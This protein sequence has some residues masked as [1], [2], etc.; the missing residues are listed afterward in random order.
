M[1]WSKKVIGKGDAGDFYKGAFRGDFLMGDLRRDFMDKKVF[2]PKA[3]VDVTGGTTSDCV[4][5]PSPIF[6]LTTGAVAKIPLVLAE[7]TVQVNVG[8]VIDLPEPAFEIKQI[9]KRVKVT[10]CILLQD[11][12]V[13][14]LKGFV[15]K[16]IDYSTSGK[17]HNKTG[18][19]GDIRHCTID[20]PWTCTT[21]V[22]FNGVNPL[23][24]VLTTNEEFV[25]FRVQDLKG[26][27]FADKD[28][29]LSSDLSEHNQISTEFY[30]ELPFC[31]L[32]SSRIVEFD[33]F[34]N[35][36]EPGIDKLPFD[37]KGYD[38]ANWCKFPFEE[39]TFKSIEEKMVIFLTLKL[40]QNQ[41]VAIPPLLPIFKPCED[42]K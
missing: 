13:L 15:R 23:P 40:L 7:F 42:N 33:E 18:F 6:S 27:D 31:E 38:A 25:Y 8:A 17:C 4:N 26:P 39:K 10:Q 1:S 41:Q 32:I 19:C 22:E 16:N 3:C 5:V 28:R 11:T 9:K 34:L 20:V 24:P 36:T 37:G 14:F 21:P 2:P 30:N 35:P 12:N 29:L